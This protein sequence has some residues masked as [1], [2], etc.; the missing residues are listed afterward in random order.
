M[1]MF[2]RAQKG[3]LAEG[4]EKVTPESGRGDRCLPRDKSREAGLRANVELLFEKPEQ[5]QLTTCYD[6]F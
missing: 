5:Q 2:F 1:F 4:A 6:S 3:S